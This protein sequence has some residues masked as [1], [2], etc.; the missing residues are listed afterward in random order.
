MR[1]E[2][3][4]IGS[5]WGTFFANQGKEK[6]LYRPLPNLTFALNWF[7]GKDDPFGYHVVNLAGHVLTAWILYQLVFQ[8]ISVPMSKAATESGKKSSGNIVSE[9]ES[10]AFLAAI[11]WAANPIQTQ[12]VTYIVQRMA[13]M[14]AF[15]YFLGMYAYVKARLSRPLIRRASFAGLCLFCYLGGIG[16]KEN[17][18]L[19][20]V[21]L[22][23]VEWIF[24]HKARLGIFTQP[25][26]LITLLGVFFV[27]LVTVF[28]TF[29]F[30][31]GR[32][33]DFFLN[34]Y[35]VRSFTMLERALTQPR[36][37]LEYLSLIFLPLPD[38]LSIVHD[39][40]LSSSL[41]YP[42]TTLPSIILVF[43]AITGAVFYAR[44]YPYL[45]FAVLFYFLNHMVESTILPLELVF[46]HRNYLPS[47]F[48]FLPVATGFYH[49]LTRLQQFN[50][51][52][53][54]AWI[55]LMTCVIVGLGVFTYERNKAWATPE[56]L[57]RDA[58]V[59]APQNSRPY[60]FLGVELAWRQ[61]ASESNFRHALVL[62]KHSLA[63]EMHR[64]TDRAK[65]LGNM[66]WVYFFQRKDDKAVDTF[67]QA[68][69]EF[70]DFDKNRRDM[71]APLMR[72]GR[73]D[74]AEYQARFLVTKF[75]GNPEYLNIL[76]IV[77]L[78]QENYESATACFQAAMR[79]EP[80]I[81]GNLLFHLGAALTRAGYLEWGD[82]F[83]SRAI[84][85]SGL[86]PMQQLARIENRVRAQ[87]FDTAGRIAR[88][89]AEEI[90]VSAII[91]LLRSLP[92]H[93]S[94]PVDVDLVRPVVFDAVADMLTENTGCKNSW[95]YA[96]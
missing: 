2:D 96:P 46:E 4:T 84:Q 78:W 42:W 23:L 89:L 22:G 68:I 82:W 47:A 45:C 43:G 13:I 70:P 59:K 93:Q 27:S 54:T 50:K 24:F 66:A 57:W 41:V 92:Q 90:P 15:F 48:L 35:D 21:S 18:I 75:P 73:V 38:R 25:K 51:T 86:H 64:K 16:S 60:I 19:L 10:M 44:R 34:G 28:L 33:F 40:T 91:D 81:N 49:V 26:T 95:I 52:G 37:I 30:S 53:Q 83:L 63:L 7:M 9:P 12:A 39:V 20:P 74:E 67:Q 80:K 69:L 29:Y 77:L 94:V 32:V 56:L 11:L 14:A 62:F 5:L 55:G 31:N 1:I 72:L 17:A 58:V 88:Q 36:I 85:H 6:A 8:L 87:D 76:G 3:L 65:T 79:F 61:H 71:I